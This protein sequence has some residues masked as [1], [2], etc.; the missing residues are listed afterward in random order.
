MSEAVTIISVSTTALLGM[1]SL[2]AAALGGSRERR[3]HTQEERATELR[4]VLESTGECL[5]SLLLAVG[6]AHDETRR[7][8]LTRD[9][10]DE[11]RD[12]EKKIVIH[13]NMIG[14]RRG[15]ESPEYTACRE[16]WLA[17]SAL[18]TILDEAG[19]QG[20]DPR[21]KGCLFKRMEEGARCRSCVP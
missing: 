8:S 10:K 16:C 5:T 13:T 21:A 15:S 3:W 12:R 11:L 20:L 4:S 17:I 6:D 7:V 9:R 1:G 19:D 18:T 2:A 14:V